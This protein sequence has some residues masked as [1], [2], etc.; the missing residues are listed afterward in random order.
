MTEIDEAV[1]LIDQQVSAGSELR[2]VDH[3]AWLFRGQP[4]PAYSTVSLRNVPVA[5]TV[6]NPTSIGPSQ[7]AAIVGMGQLLRDWQARQ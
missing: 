4:M 7:R 6:A 1:R 3:P 5:G 2:I